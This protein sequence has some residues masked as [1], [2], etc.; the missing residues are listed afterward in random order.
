MNSLDALSVSEICH[1][2]R[3]YPS[4]V[5]GVIRG[6]PGSYEPEYSLL[7]LHLV[8]EITTKVHGDRRQK[9]YKFTCRDPIALRYI[10]NTLKGYRETGEV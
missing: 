6:R 2:T 9:T 5:I 8:A 7:Q 10:E 4:E 1:K 3:L